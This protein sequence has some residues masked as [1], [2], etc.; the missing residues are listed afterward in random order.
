MKYINT[1]ERFRLFETFLWMTPYDGT[2]DPGEKAEILN[3]FLTKMD[4]GT[5]KIS[6][7]KLFDFYRKNIRSEFLPKFE[8]EVSHISQLLMMLK[9]AAGKKDQKMI[10]SYLMKLKVALQMGEDCWSPWINFTFKKVDIHGDLIEIM[11]MFDLC[12]N[13]TNQPKTPQPPSGD[14]NPPPPPPPPPPG[15]AG[16]R[17]NPPPPP[18]PPY[19]GK[20][21]ANLFIVSTSSSPI[22]FGRTSGDGSYG[23]GALVEVKALTTP[24]F[25]FRHWTEG[26]KV[27][28]DKPLF[29]F[30]IYNNRNLIANFYKKYSDD[31]G[32]DDNPPPYTGKA[33]DDDGGDDNPPPYTGKAKAG[34]RPPYGGDLSTKLKTVVDELNS[35]K[36]FKSDDAKIVSSLRIKIMI[37][38]SGNRIG[39]SELPQLK[40]LQFETFYS[41]ETWTIKPIN[42][43]PQLLQKDIIG[44]D[45]GGVFKRPRVSEFLKQID[46]EP[47]HQELIDLMPNL[48]KLNVYHG[49]SW[50]KKEKN[51]RKNT[52]QEISFDG[53]P[54]SETITHELLHYFTIPAILKYEKNVKDCTFH[55]EDYV[56]QLKLLYDFY[57]KFYKDNKLDIIEFAVGTTNKNLIKKM[58]SC[59]VRITTPEGKKENTTVYKMLF[60]ITKDYLKSLK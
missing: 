25:I 47:E 6:S 27:V 41:N 11:Q 30:R 16:R 55:E 43:K 13:K 45:D 44:D 2:Q 23:E 52:K 18:P 35:G 48:S 49:D 56:K 33:S 58:K 54:S 59:D 12:K 60:E 37:D 46:I 9:V 53:T 51:R 50:E 8:K 14:D 38:R 34:D 21:I 40:G 5:R 3:N 29:K 7:T 36:T 1:F 42:R 28:S 39:V 20:A 32:G 26:D 17:R 22:G 19:T 15:A 10:Q 4:V 31:D 57:V 24:G